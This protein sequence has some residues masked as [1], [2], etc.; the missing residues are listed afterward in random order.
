MRMNKAVPL[1]FFLAALL[2]LGILQAQPHATISAAPDLW[3]E[4]TPDPGT[5]WN[6]STK[7]ANETSQKPDYT[8]TIK[9]PVLDSAAGNAAKAAAFN[10]AVEK[11]RAAAVTDFKQSSAD[12]IPN[13]PAGSYLDISYDIFVTRK[14]MVSVRF[15]IDQYIGGAAHPS[16]ASYTLNYNQATSKVLTLADLF[17]PGSKYLDIIAKY[18]TDDLKRQGRLMIPEGAT[19]KAENYQNWNLDRGGLLITFDPYQV[20]PYAEGPSE[21][22][23]PYTTLGDALKIDTF[24]L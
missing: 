13:T 16:H 20:G 4:A 6:I 7:T 12:G 23:I 24:D 15:S 17:K 9:L 18:S 1:F 14:G 8:I 5:I 22:F 11:F 10:A 3:I 2:T 19:A 21:V